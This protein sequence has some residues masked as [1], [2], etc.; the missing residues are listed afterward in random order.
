MHGEE[1]K[2]E[3][4]KPEFDDDFPGGKPVLLFA[5]IEHQLQCADAHGQDEEARP[6][7]AQSLRLFIFLE[8]ENE[9]GNG[10]NAKGEIDEEDPAPVIDICQITAERWPEN[11]ANHDTHAPHGHGRSA[12]LDRIEIEQGGLG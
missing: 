9:T 11:G 4:G 10:E 7:E 6:V 12:L 5:T 3:K 2:A 1:I 8:K